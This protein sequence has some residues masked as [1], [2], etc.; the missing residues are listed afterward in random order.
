M[1]SAP[2]VAAKVCGLRELIY[3]YTYR[4]TRAHIHT[5]IHTDIHAYSAIG[6]PWS[7][8]EGSQSGAR[9]CIPGSLFQGL[10]SLAA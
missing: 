2:E 4:H 9:R 3:T 5:Y 7:G 1:L 8:A 10:V 6:Q